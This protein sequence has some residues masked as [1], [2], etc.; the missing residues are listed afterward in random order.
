MKYDFGLTSKDI[1]TIAH[2]MAIR[3]VG[4]EL[5]ELPFA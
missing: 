3:P 5:K 1:T 4:I 2:F